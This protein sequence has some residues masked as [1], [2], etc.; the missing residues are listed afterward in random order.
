MAPTDHLALPFF[1]AAHRRLGADLSAWVPQQRID[2]RDDR[3]ACR[4]WVRALG[5]AGW[6]RYCVPAE[7]GGALE[8]MDSRALVILRETLAFHS[9]LADFAFAMQGLGS[10]AITLAGTP[11]QQAAYLPAVARGDKIAAFALSEPDAGSDAGAMK[12]VAEKIEATRVGG[13]NGLPEEAFL[14]HGC[15]T[16]ISNGGMADYYCVFAKTAPQAGTRGITAFIVDANTPGL[17]SSEH[18][19]VMAPH[20]LATLRFSGCRLPASAQLGELHGGFKL[21]MRTLDIFRASVAAAALGMARRALAEAVDYARHR[22][23]FGQ[24]LADFQLT[25]ARLGEMAALIDAAAGLTY[26]AAWMRDCVGTDEPA[27]AQAYTAAAAMAKMTATENAQRV[28]DMALQMHGGLGVK[29]G[30]KVESLYR[31][32]RALRIYEGATEVQQ[33]II[34]KSLLKS[35]TV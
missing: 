17:D 29:V 34:G 9:P 25:Q 1:D 24:R 27:Q 15:K 30:V 10:G 14:L 7:Q 18:I 8:R 33:L 16:W 31:D 28:I 22:P 21:A 11:A 23:M 35:P 12:T 32:I 2:E 13:Q 20:P 4:D 3:Q 26:R 19:E 5:D 6:L